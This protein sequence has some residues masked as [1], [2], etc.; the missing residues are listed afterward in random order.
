MKSRIRNF[1]F[2]ALAGTPHRASA[3]TT[4][5]PPA[6]P[7]CKGTHIPKVVVELDLALSVLPLL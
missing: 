4:P 2:A 3:T 1:A 6:S 7:A 5:I